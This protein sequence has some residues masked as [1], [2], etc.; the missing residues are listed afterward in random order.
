[1]AAVSVRSSWSTS[2]SLHVHVD[3]HAAPLR[4]GAGHAIASGAR[5]APAGLAAA[6]PGTSS[7]ARDHRRDRA[8]AANAANAANSDASPPYRS[9]TVPCPHLKRRR[10]SRRVDVY[11]SPPHTTP[12][13]SAHGPMVPGVPGA[14]LWAHVVCEATAQLA[15]ALA[16]AIDLVQASPCHCCHGNND[17]LHD[18]QHSHSCTVHHPPPPPHTATS[19][20]AR[21]A[22]PGFVPAPMDDCPHL[23]CPFC[24]NSR[25]PTP[26]CCPAT[27]ATAA[28][29]PAPA[30]APSTTTV[31]PSRRA[32][33]SAPAWR[34]ATAPP[35]A[36]PQ[37]VHATTIPTPAAPPPL[38]PQ[39]PVQAV[40]RYRST[41]AGPAVGSTGHATWPRLAAAAPPPP[42]PL[43][44]EK[45]RPAA[46]AS[47]VKADPQVAALRAELRHAAEVG[48]ALLAKVEHTHGQLQQLRASHD[49]L[50]SSYAALSNDYARL[51]AERDALMENRAFLSKELD[52]AQA[53]LRQAELALATV[54]AEQS[55]SAATLTSVHQELRA[56]RAASK[57]VRTERDG[58]AAQLEHAA[59]Q[60]RQ[61]L[62]D[63]K[64]HGDLV[65]ARIAERNAVQ[66]KLRQTEAYAA[67]VEAALAAARDQWHRRLDQAMAALQ[68]AR[69]ERQVVVAQLHVLENRLRAKQDE[70]DALAVAQSVRAVVAAGR[71]NIDAVDAEVQVLVE[72]PR[73]VCD[74]GTQFSPQE[75]P[76]Q[77]GTVLPRAVA[78]P[79][80]TM[81]DQPLTPPPSPPRMVTRETQT[82]PLRSPRRD[83]PGSPA[84]MRAHDSPMLFGSRMSRRL[85]EP[86]ALSPIIAP[87]RSSSASTGPPLGSPLISMTSAA[88]HPSPVASA[89][90]TS[91]ASPLLQRTL[92]GGGGAVPNS[93]SLRRTSVQIRRGSAA[94]MQQ[95]PT[96][97]S[98]AAVAAAAAAAASA[99]HDLSTISSSD[100]SQS[101]LDLNHMV[102]G[103]S[104]Q[105]LME[106]NVE[107]THASSSVS[108]QYEP[109]WRLTIT[110]HQ[111]S[112]AHTYAPVPIAAPSP[113]AV[114]P[115][116]W[117][118][119]AAS[120]PPSMSLSF[121]TEET[122]LGGDDDDGASFG[123][124][125]DLDSL[126]QE[127]L[128][129]PPH[130]TRS[131]AVASNRADADLH[132]H[133]DDEM[134]DHEDD[135]DDDCEGPG[136]G[137]MTPAARSASNSS[138]STASHMEEAFDSLVQIVRSQLLEMS[139]MR[140]ALGQVT[141]AYT[142]T[143]DKLARAQT[144]QPPT[145]VPTPAPPPPPPSEPVSR[146]VSPPT[147]WARLSRKLSSLRRM[148]IDRARDPALNYLLKK[149]QPS[150]RR[151]NSVSSNATANS[152]R[153]STSA[154]A[155][156]ATPDV[157]RAVKRTA[158]RSSMALAAAWGGAR[159]GM[160][161]SSTPAPAR[162]PTAPPAPV[163]RGEIGAAPRSTPTF[164]VPQKPNAD[165]GSR[166]SLTLE[167]VPL[168]T[169]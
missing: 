57:A 10:S 71:P 25:L 100:Q 91:M 127:V 49:A 103:G 40:T 153:L 143:M 54:M 62:A 18:H 21:P 139:E 72:E 38:P 101:T 169:Q 58:L 35:V 13:P 156:I 168:S 55:S 74:S 116:G 157:V 96:A 165:N 11:F 33:A 16:S 94:S 15:P 22:T 32:S 125:D 46:A 110:D 60:R 92:A 106:A 99:S 119:R 5:S 97:M 133:E 144:T 134:T 23:D 67:K 108:N 64:V 34:P 109:D 160:S 81:N 37:L 149:I 151:S 90:S 135:E 30:P 113:M 129:L 132:L 69:A 130:I 145:A 85:I 80:P 20:T 8:A 51:R 150:S 76:R 14:P 93:P 164:L 83:V 26:P 48:Q 52:R 3:P 73:D 2:R 45:S 6:R 17:H 29:A 86:M 87:R 36:A 120:P 123:D 24:S 104:L 147:S 27:H 41:S 152:S 43:P 70:V 95:V 163:A 63:L 121:V 155:S 56:A 105:A 102:V 166:N 31:Y 131:F 47:V 84:S 1:M 42:P 142:E 159:A 4:I 154:P 82:D 118:H 61:L 66:D 138:S 44:A 53:A 68:D 137:A 78:V 65:V 148:S 114:D 88:A 7:S 112:S 117:H 77:V 107:D 19:P 136:G 89:Q 162:P 122:S 141:Q 50:R 124:D 75:S 59:T 79:S 12:A 115:W 28:S 128:E 167:K 126:E 9:A 146:T 39:G 161:R 111:P 98:A 140:R 158:S